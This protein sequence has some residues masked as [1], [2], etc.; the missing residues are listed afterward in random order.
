MCHNQLQGVVCTRLTCCATIGKAWG[1]P[2]ERCPVKPGKLALI[3]LCVFLTGIESIVCLLWICFSLA[4]FVNDDWEISSV[5][6]PSNGNHVFHFPQNL[7]TEDFS[8]I[9]A[10]KH[11]KVISF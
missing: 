5:L 4:L 6:L 10:A 2:C 7:V 8:Q 11:V 9:F 3:R 1:N